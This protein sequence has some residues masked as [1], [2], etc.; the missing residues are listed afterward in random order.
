MGLMRKLVL[1]GVILLPLHILEQLFF[2]FERAFA[3][4]GAAI[5]P[6][7]R[8]F[9][10]PDKGVLAALAIGL[11]PLATAI[12]FALG[13]S[14]EQRIACA[15][16]GVLLLPEA[17]HIIRAFFVGGYYPGMVTGALMCLT[18]VLLLK[19]VLTAQSDK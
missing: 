6:L 12:Y 9:D 19:I 13:N 4:V 3:D 5:A 2:G 17:H 1:F 8:L 14:K 15:I 18:G 7:G 16:F 11:I 10:D